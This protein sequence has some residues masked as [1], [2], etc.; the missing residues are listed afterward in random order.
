MLVPTGY[1]LSAHEIECSLVTLLL[2]FFISMVLLV[3]AITLIFLLVKLHYCEEEHLLVD[4]KNM[5][6]KISL[7]YTQMGL[8]V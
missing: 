6:E 8:H 7:Q 3:L 1:S 4:E 5:D 2:I